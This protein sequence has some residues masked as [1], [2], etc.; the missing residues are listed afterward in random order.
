MTAN[1]GITGTL[2]TEKAMRRIDLN[3]D[4]GESFGNWCMGDDETVLGIVSSAN[5]ACGF[6]AGDAQVMA[7][8]CEIAKRNG[9]SVGAHPGFADLQGFGRRPIPMSTFELET[10]VAYQIGAFIGIAARA[11]LRV[12]HVKAHG[13]LYNLAES[14]AWVA[15]AI[16]RAVKAVDPV[17]IMIGGTGSPMVGAA[18]AAG[19]RFAAEGFPDRAYADDGKLLSRKLP[20]AVLHDPAAA[21]AQA[22]RMAVEGQILT[23]G[24][25]R[26]PAR[27]DTLCIHGD[28]PTAA[29]VAGGI[30]SALAAAGVEIAALPKILGA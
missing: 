7:R 30:K 17:L 27:V 29:A 16:A 22:V 5:V 9:V 14:D 24:G 8:T 2:N 3:A 13:A 25:K 23:V 28:E 15:G 10:M 18:E 12:A 21:A 26:L 4:V 1:A 6:H 11:G 20:G 19:V